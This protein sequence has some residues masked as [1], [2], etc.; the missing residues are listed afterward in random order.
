MRHLKHKFGALVLPRETR[1]IL[2][3][4]ELITLWGSLSVL[5]LCVNFS[6]INPEGPN[7]EFFHG[8]HR[9]LMVEAK[10]L[11]I[12]VANVI[13]LVSSKE[14]LRKLPFF[15]RLESTKLSS[16]FLPTAWLL[17]DWHPTLLVTSVG[18]QKEETTDKFRT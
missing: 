3:W 12:P 4:R 18:Q 13:G 15:F 2:P 17:W 1:C 5:S 6:I 16:H 14:S 11:G 8:R 7:R 10:Q 9:V